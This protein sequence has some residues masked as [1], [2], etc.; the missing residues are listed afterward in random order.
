[1]AVFWLV[2]KC[3]LVKV[4]RRFRDPCCLHQQGV[5]ITELRVLEVQEVKIP[6]SATF[7]NI[8]KHVVKHL[9]S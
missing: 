5:Q 1:M 8:D 7:T 2:A 3:C 9:N 4:Y 6:Y